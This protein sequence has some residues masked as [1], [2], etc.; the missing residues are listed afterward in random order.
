[1]KRALY[2]LMGFVHPLGYEIL[3]GLG[4]VT[5]L[6]CFLLQDLLEPWVSLLGDRGEMGA[7]QR[8]SDQGRETWSESD[9]V[10]MLC[11]LGACFLEGPSLHPRSWEVLPTELWQ[12]EHCHE[13]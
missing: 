13:L 4:S 1:M 12:P 7:T 3:L 9:Q 6:T 5:T 11:N 2:G 8:R 10:K